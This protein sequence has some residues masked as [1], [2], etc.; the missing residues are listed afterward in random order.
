[1]GIA[2]GL[3][4]FANV[5][6]GIEATDAM[7]KAADVELLLARPTCP[8]K[9]TTL[10]SGDVGAVKSSVAAGLAVAADAVVDEF[11]LPN[12]HPGVFPAITATSDVKEVKALGVIET[13]TVASAIVAADAALKAAAVDAIEL[14]LAIG[15]GGKCFVTLTGEVG[16]VQAAIAAGSADASAKGLLVGRVV[17]PSP[18]KE[19]V[20]MLL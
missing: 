20:R 19:L 3:V 5:T 15:L 11:I 8:G 9:Y 10:V 18:A 2:I 13:F 14:R 6:K 16:A 7:V 4:E 1:M 17:I 12:V